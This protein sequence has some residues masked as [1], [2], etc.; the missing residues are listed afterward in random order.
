[1]ADADAVN[2]L[3]SSKEKVPSNKKKKKE[4]LH[5]ICINVLLVINKVSKTNLPILWSYS[6]SKYLLRDNSDSENQT[7]IGTWS[8]FF[9]TKRISYRYT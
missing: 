7:E 8:Y 2:K 4:T 6:Y 1:M 9:S 3:T 5:G